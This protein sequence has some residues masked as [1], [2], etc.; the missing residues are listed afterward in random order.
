ME[1]AKLIATVEK[2]WLVVMSA[3]NAL[4]M[5]ADE[6]DKAR[7]KT[8]EALNDR[9][10][11]IEYDFGTLVR[12]VITDT[13][14]PTVRTLHARLDDL[15]AE[16]RG[17]YGLPVKAAIKALNDRIDALI[18]DN[19]RNDGWT[20]FGYKDGQPIRGKIGVTVEEAFPDD[21]A[22][23]LYPDH[24][25]PLDTKAVDNAANDAL[26]MDLVRDSKAKKLSE[27]E[28]GIPAFINELIDGVAG[29]YE[30]VIL[31]HEG[32]IDTLK[33]E[34]STRDRLLDD[35]AATIGKLEDKLAKAKR[36]LSSSDLM[37]LWSIPRKMEEP[38][39]HPLSM[40]MTEMQ[41]DSTKITVVYGYDIDEG[42]VTVYAKD[43]L[44]MNP[45]LNGKPVVDTMVGWVS[46]QFTN[47]RT[48]TKFTVCNAGVFAEQVAS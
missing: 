23:P 5:E 6:S 13:D 46:A 10:S 24:V 9:L 40:D 44:G 19:I 45:T 18:P 28:A 31:E 15:E 38:D 48:G 37:F 36:P 8:I 17:D 34:I 14:K 33:T 35:Q 21:D 25:N 43:A 1:N 41:I 26:F 16:T 20:T 22:L 12:T 7:L 3:A 2:L 4:G 29:P 39:V 32:T 30:G 42:T 47:P 11:T 27:H